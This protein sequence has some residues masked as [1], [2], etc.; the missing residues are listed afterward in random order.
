MP[1]ARSRSPR[2]RPPPDPPVKLEDKCS[3]WTVLL[4]AALHALG[5]A[6]FLSGESR[7]RRA[8]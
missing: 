8:P 1:R 6:L 2:A 4:V 7:E 5:I 3:R